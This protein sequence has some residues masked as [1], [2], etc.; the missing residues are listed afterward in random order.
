MRLL[1]SVYFCECRVRWDWGMLRAKGGWD[2][3]WGGILLGLRLG[4]TRGRVTLR[5]GI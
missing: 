2:D 5:S 4:A 1:C 3:L